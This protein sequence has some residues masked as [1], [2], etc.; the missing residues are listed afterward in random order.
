MADILE[1]HEAAQALQMFWNLKKQRAISLKDFREYKELL[2]AKML[3][4]S[5]PP[6][7]KE[8]A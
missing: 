6:R 5:P 7:E 2:D 1:I 3:T 8:E 4:K